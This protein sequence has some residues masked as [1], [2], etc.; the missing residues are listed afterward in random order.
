MNTAGDVRPPEEQEGGEEKKEEKGEK[1]EQ[2]EAEEET[3]AGIRRPIKMQ[4]PKEPSDE[5]RREH[6]LTHLPYRSWCKYCVGGR[7]KEAPH[8]R[9]EH[10]GDLPEL[11]LDYA[12]MGDEGEAGKT[13]TILVA[14]ERRTRMTMSTVVPS[15]SSGSFVIERVWAFMKE[16]GIEG[17]DTVVKSDQEPSIKHLVDEIGRRKAEVGGRWIRENSPVDSHASNGVVERAIQSVQGQ[18]RTMKGAL[19]DRWGV[20][21]G[22]K[23]A[24][25]P[26]IVEYAAHLLNRFEVSHDGKTAYE[27][28]KGKSAKHMGIEFGEGVLWRR[29][30]IG[31][32]M[33]KMTILWEEGVFLGVKG[34]TGEFI[35]GSP[36][37]VWKTRTLQRTPMTTRWARSNAEF[38]ARGPLED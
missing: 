1:G 6:N 26:W 28:Y 38:G 13:L 16:L 17:Q 34:R 11:H 36:K 2:V 9:Q 25:I 8:R 32:A 5:E 10:Q 19:E 31:G 21:I 15:K 29:R 24:V 30:P 23:H 37:G 35:I 12:F 18:V 3:E 4:D 7:G 20:K 14:R 27:R 22:S 33:A